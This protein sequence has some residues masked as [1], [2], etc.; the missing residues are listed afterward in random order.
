SRRLGRE[1]GEVVTHARRGGE[2]GPGQSG[3]STSL[4]SE[5]GENVAPP[6]EQSDLLLAGCEGEVLTA[7]A[8]DRGHRASGRVVHDTRP[9]ETAPV[10][11]CLEHVDAGEE[12]RQRWLLVGLRSRVE[13][14]QRSEPTTA[15]PAR[16]PAGE[17][18][19]KV[20]ESLATDTAER[21]RGGEDGRR[22]CHRQRQTRRDRGRRSEPACAEHGELD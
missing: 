22:G 7:N 2:V 17:D 10:A 13:Q 16:D 8:Y 12:R 15:A 6:C 11:G 5:C 14:V 3:H 18:G 21:E 9:G 20:D 4:R 19:E 1:P